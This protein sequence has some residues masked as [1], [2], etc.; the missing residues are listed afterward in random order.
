[1]ATNPQE[2]SND[3][4]FRICEDYLRRITGMSVDFLR[5]EE[6]KEKLD[7]G[8]ARDAEGN[9]YSPRKSSFQQRRDK[10]TSKRQAD[11]QPEPA[12]CDKCKAKTDEQPVKK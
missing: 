6:L 2:H 7:L 11:A 8:I 4:L 10:E 3:A 1:M 5:S 9:H 12:R